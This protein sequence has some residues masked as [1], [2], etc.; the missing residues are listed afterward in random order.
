MTQRQMFTNAYRMI[1][2]EG[3]SHQET[4]DELKPQAYSDLDQLAKEVSQTP[5]SQKVEETKSLRSIFMVVITLVFG[6]HILELVAIDN[7]EAHLAWYISMAVMSV[8]FWFLGIFAA[9][10]A[11]IYMYRSCAG[12]LIITAILSLANTDYLTAI[13]LILIL[14]L[15]VGGIVL[16]FV[17]PAKSK[18]PFE[19]T[20]YKE[21]INGKE[22]SLFRF[23]FEQSNESSVFKSRS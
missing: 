18:T 12:F 6:L 21:M 13:E 15:S 1:V 4:F 20:V 17:I 10:K 7:I 14:A 8:G 9:L 5:S 11:R 22:K 23:T 19:R 3:K 16:A 2:K